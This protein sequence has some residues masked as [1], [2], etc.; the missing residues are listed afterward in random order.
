MPIPAYPGIPTRKG[1][2]HVPTV[3]HIQSALTAMGIGDG[4]TD[5]VFDTAMESA[6]RLFQSRNVDTAGV[7]LKVDGIVGRFT[8]I[9]LFGIAEIDSLPLMPALARLPAQML[10]V[11]TTQI[12]VRELPGQPNRGPQVDQY[13]KTTG[14]A[15]PAGNPPGGYAWCQA[16]LYWCAVQACSALGRSDIPVPKTA[17]VLK[18]WQMAA[19]APGVRRITTSQALTNPALVTPGMFF[20]LDFGSGQGH[21]GLVERLYPDGRLVTI[22]GNSNATGS[23]DGIGVYRLERRK[24]TSDPREKLKGF[25]DF[26]AA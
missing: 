23:R 12:G 17:G 20:T 24:L 19:S 8:W 11:A 18:H 3:Q 22:E 5:N 16:F 14:I 4:L 26:S 10:A 21:T 13:L 9:A 2:S 15:N 1:D 25:V 7:P 6:V